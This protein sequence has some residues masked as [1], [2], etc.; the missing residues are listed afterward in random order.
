MHLTRLILPLGLAAACVLAGQARAE[1]HPKPA[2]AAQAAP[3][4]EPAA[5][6]S[7]RTSQYAHKWIPMPTFTASALPHHADQRTVGPARGRVLVLVFLASWCEACQQVT[8]RLREIEQRYGRLN[9]DFVYVFAHDTPQDA[10]GFMQEFK[11]PAGVLAS[12]EAL[13]AYNN[14]ELP[15][16]YVGDRRG[17]LTTR[18]VN[19]AEPQIQKLSDLLRYLTAF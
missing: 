15:S 13:K 16:V 7:T 10:E 1:D 2:A 11:L 17:W 8:P 14:P 19:I 4:A 18:Y 5:A 3:H 9:T 6:P 12:Y